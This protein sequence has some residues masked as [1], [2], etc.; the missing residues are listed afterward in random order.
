MEEEEETGSKQ[1]TADDEVT[2]IPETMSDVSVADNVL[3][4]CT[5]WDFESDGATISDA[6]SEENENDF[7]QWTDSMDELVASFDP[8]PENSTAAVTTGLGVG[9]SSDGATSMISDSVVGTPQRS[10]AGISTANRASGLGVDESRNETT[11]ILDSP[12]RRSGVAEILA[13]NTT[14]P[15]GAKRHLANTTLDSLNEPPTSRQRQ[16]V[17]EAVADGQTEMSPL[18]KTLA[19]TLSLRSS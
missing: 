5:K 17:G 18:R 13:G 10:G 14:S 7:S 8:G 19:S 12:A 16:I 1:Q 15:T 3:E 11:S 4:M 9:R 6:A 2:S